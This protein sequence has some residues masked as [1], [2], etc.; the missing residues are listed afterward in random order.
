MPLFVCAYWTTLTLLDPLAAALLLARP[1]L[2]VMLTVAIITI[3]VALNVWVG[4]TRGF[5]LDAL[6]AQATF[7]QSPGDD[8]AGMASATFLGAVRGAS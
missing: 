4:A 3:D 5:Q 2:G 8:S 6:I 1:R 7:L